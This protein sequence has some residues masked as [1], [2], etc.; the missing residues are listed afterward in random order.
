MSRF[1]PLLA[2]ILGGCPTAIAWQSA[3]SQDITC[4]A[5]ECRGTDIMGN[6]ILLRVNSDRLDSKQNYTARIGGA[7]I[8]VER[9]RSQLVSA[10]WN[11]PVLLQ[12][13]VTTIGGEVDGRSVSL[14]TESSGLT[15]GE[16]FGQPITCAAN[17]WSIFSPSPCF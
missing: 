9:E 2:L 11:G 14:Y 10:G 13:P 16:A 15:T 6:P 17:G 12:R 4:T 5:R 1:Q 8:E 3:Y 7:E